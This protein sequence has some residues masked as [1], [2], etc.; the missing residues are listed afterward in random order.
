[1][2]DLLEK[3]RRETGT[4]KFALINKTCQT[5]IDL[6]RNKEAVSQTPVYELREKC[7]EAFQLSLESHS[8]KLSSHAVTGI[9][10]LLKDE[11]FQSSMESERENRWLPMQVLTA[12]WSLP[13]LAEEAQVEI[14]KVLLNMS[15]TTVWCMNAKVIIKISEVLVDTYPCSSASVRSASKATITQMLAS[16]AEKLCSTEEKWVGD[17]ADDILADFKAKDEK[18]GAVMSIRQDI[19]CI[20]KFLVIRLSSSWQGGPQNKLVIPLL[21]EGIHAILHNVPSSL[22]EFTDFSDLVWQQLCPG[23]IGLLGNPKAEG[24]LSQ[25]SGG[26][27][28]DDRGRGS[29][30]ST[31]APSLSLQASRVVY[32]ISVELVRLV[33][34]KLSLRPV[35]ES[36]FHRML[37]FPPPQYRHEALKAVR[38]MVSN[39]DLVVTLVLPTLDSSTEKEKHPGGHK[40]DIGL[41]KLMIDSLKECCHCTDSAV[42]ITSVECVNL[43]LRG[44]EQLCVGEGLTP[45]IT[46]RILRLKLHIYQQIGQSERISV[47]DIPVPLIRVETA[48]ISDQPTEVTCHPPD[49]TD[50]HRVNDDKDSDSARPTPTSE[51]KKDQDSPRGGDEVLPNATCPQTVNL[52]IDAG[53]SITMTKIIGDV[54]D[55][56]LEETSDDSSFQNPN[57][58]EAIQLQLDEER[59]LQIQLRAEMFKTK[60]EDM[61][62]QSAKDFSQVLSKFLPVLLQEYS[63]RDVD[64]ALV[65][66]AS[67]FCQN[68]CSQQS[69]EE[70]TDQSHVILN[71]DGV[72]MAT[73]SALWLNLRLSLSGFYTDT[74]SSIPPIS[75]DWFV[76]SVLGTGLLLFLSPTW[77]SE[78]YRLVITTDFLVEAGYVPDIEATR[79]VPL[80]SFLTDLDGLGSH[81]RGRQLLCNEQCD[82]IIPPAGDKRQVEAGKLL[83]RYILTS[84]WDGI[85]DVMSV[86]LNGDSSCG[87]S[88]SLG[89]MLGI[90]GAKEE[91]LKAREAI[92]T[93]LEGLQKAARLCC[94]LGLQGRCGSVF[95]LLANSSCVMD[96]ILQTPQG[97][98]KG[99]KP[100]GLPVKPKLVRL[101]AAHVLSMDVVMTMGLE[102][103]SHSADCWSHVFRCCAHISELEHKYF[104]SGNNQSNLPKVLPGQ[105]IEREPDFMSG[106][107]MQT[108]PVA[109]AP[110][111]NVPELIKQ[112]G[113]EAGWDS[114]LSGGG[115]LSASQTAKALCGLSQEV[116]RLFEDAANKLNMGALLGF[117][118]ELCDASQIQLSKSRR[119]EDGTEGVV[120]AA[121]HLPTNALHLYRLQDVMMRLLHSGRP[122]LHLLRAWTVVSPYLAEA[123]GHIDRNISKMAVSC[124]HGYITAMVSN[125]P[126]LPHFHVN[127]L[128]CKTLETLLCLDLC[129]G[130]VQDQVVCSICELVEACTAEIRSGWRPLFAALR[131]VKIEY[132]ANEEVNE[133]RQRHVTAVLDVFDVFL[134]TDNVHVFANATVDCILCLLKYVRGPGEFQAD[135]D[136]DSDSGSDAGL[137]EPGADENLAEPALKYLEKCCSI[138]SSMWKIPVCPAFSGAHRIHS[139]SSPTLV[140]P[141]IPNIDFDGFKRAFIEEE[142]E[143]DRDG[144][145]DRDMED[146]DESGEGNY[147]SITMAEFEAA[148]DG[149][150]APKSPKDKAQLEDKSHQ[151]VSDRNRA[152]SECKASSKAAVTLVNL[153]ELDNPTGILHVW[154]LVLEGLASAIAV[155]PKSY[156]PQT[157]EMLFELLRSAANVPGPEFA[158]FCVN[159]LVLPMLQSWL[160]RSTRL[161]GYWEGPVANFKQCC[162]LCTDLVVE[163]VVLFSDKGAVDIQ[164]D[165]MLKQLLDVLIE[166]VALPVEVISRLGCSCIKHLL[167]SSGPM[168]PEPMWQI[169]ARG[170]D[171]AIEVTTYRVRQLML[172]F[173][174]NSENF[175]GD[176]GQV[177][178]ATRKDS[179]VMECQRLRH[180]AQQV[181]LLDNQ[182]TCVGQMSYDL[183]TDKSYVFLLYPP[184]CETSLNPD[185]I[186]TRVP[187]HSVVVGLLSHQLLL[188][189]VG[190]ILLQ[191]STN[192][193]LQGHLQ[194]QLSP[195]HTKP[196]QNK[197]KDKG[198]MPG[199]LHHLSTRNVLQL[200]DTLHSSYTVA[201]DFDQRPGLKFLVQKVAN[202]DMAANLYKQAV[203]SMTY[204]IS[205]LVEICSNL[206]GGTTESTRLSL[207]GGSGLPEGS[208]LQ[209]PIESNPAVFYQ[210][211]RTACDDVSETYVALVLDKEGTSAMDRMAEKPLFFLIAQAE[212]LPE[213]SKEKRWRT[214]LEEKLRQREL[215]AGSAFSAPVPLEEQVKPETDEMED[216]SSLPF[217]AETGSPVR[218]KSKRESR[219]EK[220]SKVYTV[221]TDQTIRSLITQYKRRKQQNSMPNLAK[222]GK[223]KSADKSVEELIEEEQQTSIMKDSEAHLK[224]WSE[225]LVT[226]LKL[227]QSVSDEKFLALLPSVFNAVNL[228]I[229]RAEDS[230]LREAMGDWFHRVG[231]LLHLTPNRPSAH[232]DSAN[233][234]CAKQADS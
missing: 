118:G 232:L 149:N 94:S 138:L 169:A 46:Q 137:T 152:G 85:L 48:S 82:E 45:E 186:L 74:E 39:L 205:T 196:G 64:N 109:V 229:C 38:Q 201:R 50:E 9:R 93:S 89:L 203:T 194:I 122:L 13:S 15:F 140:D 132:T 134:S 187:F 200:L 44:L 95:A 42:C 197:L 57:V 189:T 12:V 102:M 174:A 180:L 110:R 52:P 195:S 72:Y 223:R 121:S 124:I 67:N 199:L 80:I 160:R 171:R 129:D 105:V 100:P 136:D 178:V 33:G 49:Q 161:Y 76:D 87:I 153:D 220:E 163:F 125:S 157:L 90:E 208:Q 24:T 128:L 166:C 34:G 230:N 192:P 8:N 59:H 156:Q 162:G 127:E 104:S 139:G 219:E 60:F 231:S 120:L 209:G 84:C 81:D 224:A 179:T 99:P 37:L 97:D 86:L 91:S 29:G 212:E 170:M 135:L 98:R 164:L 158:L 58:H 51:D 218:T 69:W 63:V 78:L 207:D 126:E 103:G 184:G 77:L 151:K 113:I 18:A 119:Q 54:S 5:A 177:K 83:S 40:A 141:S 1:M 70:N 71:A 193:A 22:G 7:L 107:L 56:D 172:L 101:H 167:L 26:Q 217:D 144:E 150:P 130:D 115:V 96:D 36:L 25:K 213:F 215:Q 188:Q 11:R 14:M 88:S 55:E 43:L 10:L 154:Y 173:Q 114:A 116:D 168:L 222:G 108:V 148:E 41:L 183:E 32:S 28:H 16:F 182:M 4:P 30:T 176:I 147:H 216:Q 175:Y 6:L 17:D 112:S 227:F 185:D 117:L 73:I 165:L 206:Q 23:I 228:L 233:Q 210:Y 143:G 3:I 146:S 221:A 155:C 181:F 191:G 225:L 61:E 159:H 19:V 75:E 133:A 53:N 111:I 31:A 35:L 47:G 198:N 190:T 123:A 142:D 202:T 234:I 21:L 92:C 65:K 62:R 2:E 27:V 79:D 68:L 226:T 211:L 131:A 145:R 106:F 204:Y 66:F 20:L 214:V